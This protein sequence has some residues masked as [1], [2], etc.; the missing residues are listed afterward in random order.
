MKRIALVGFTGWAGIVWLAWTL[1]DARLGPLC[2]Y[3]QLECNARLVA[4]RDAVL[5][6]GLTVA[7]VG[8]LALMLV[9]R[10]PDQRARLSRLPPILPAMFNAVRSR[11]WLIGVAVAVALSSLVWFMVRSAQ[12]PW[13]ETGQA[14]AIIVPSDAVTEP[15]DER[16]SDASDLSAAAAPAGVADASSKTTQRSILIPDEGDPFATTSPQ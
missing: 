3:R 7:L 1:A 8:L 6:N 9:T 10:Q 2:R 14:D 13:R 16:A 15:A 4:Q 11:S 12:W 5:T